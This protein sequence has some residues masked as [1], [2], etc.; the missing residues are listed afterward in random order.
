MAFLSLMSSHLPLTRDFGLTMAAGIAAT[1]LSTIALLPGVLAHMTPHPAGARRNAGGL[2][3]R[4]LTGAARVNHRHGR[5]VIVVVAA[6]ASFGLMGARRLT[7]EQFATGDL[8]PDDPVRTVQRVLDDSLMGS[9][10]TEVLVRLPEGMRIDT[11]AGLREIEALQDWLAT[12]GATDDRPAV[13]KAWSI[14]DY[15]KGLSLDDGVRRIPE[16]EATLQSYLML[17]LG[18][19]RTEEVPSLI[20]RDGRWAIIRLGTSDLGAERLLRLEADAQEFVRSLSPTMEVRFLGDYWLASLG[21]S[22]LIRDLSVSMLTSL[23]MVFAAVGLA[24]RSWRLT[25]L[26]IPPNLLP[27]IAA[28][29]FM[30]LTDISLRVGTSI[31]LPMSLG[32][33]VDATVHLLARFR[34]ECR[35]NGDHEAAVERALIGTG[36][37]LLVSAIVLVGGFLAFLVPDFLVYR[38]IGLI[39]SWTLLCALFA[40]LL[41]TPSLVLWAR[42]FD[43][44]G[45]RAS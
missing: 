14:V 33:A 19:S 2:V 40:D 16:D 10:H 38:Q 44:A 24:L 7:V 31:I 45:G 30:G 21:T 43:R 12:P 27:P 32:L 23:F 15:V 20:D 28:L 18:Q 13:V 36:R 11:P 3:G 34:E 8:P 42:P 26:A 1:F 6:L 22:G 37:G 41:F 39:A 4:V 35:L 29:A 25:L 17:L 9:F 5:V